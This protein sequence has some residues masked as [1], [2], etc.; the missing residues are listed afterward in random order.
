MEKLISRIEAFQ[1]DPDLVKVFGC[2][3]YSN[4][5]PWIKKV[6]RDDDFWNALNEISGSKWAIFSARAADGKYEIEDSSSPQAMSFL[7]PVWVEPQENQEL[8]DLL[9]LD[10]TEKP[11]FTIFTP[12][13]STNEFLKATLPLEDSSIESTYKRL[14]HVIGELTIAVERIEKENIENREEV[15]NAINMT[16]KSIRQWDTIKGLIGIYNWYKNLKP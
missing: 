8:I 11:L 9:G 12:I 3:V 4:R 7:V 16:V 15:F 13:Q 10:S 14:K 2:I 1:Y 6:L 5:H